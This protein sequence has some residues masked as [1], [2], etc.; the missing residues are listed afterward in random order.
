MAKNLSE[1]E[2]YKIE[3]YLKAGIRPG[4][5]AK[6]L[7]RCRATIYNEI[8]R[9]TCIQIDSELREYKTY[10]ADAGERVH[11]E[12]AAEKGR[13]PKIGN[14]MEF[15][16]HV[17]HMTN[18][19]KYSPFAIIADIENRGLDF[20]TKVCERTL[21][22][23]IKN[24]TFLNIKAKSKQKHE[25]KSKVSLN[26][27]KGRSIEERP[28][29]IKDRASYGHWEMDT[30]VSGQGKSKACLLVLTERAVR[31]EII[32]KMDNKKAESTVKALNSLEKK[33][34]AKNFRETFKTITVDNGVEFLDCSG[35]EKSVINKKLPR[36]T[37]YYCH[38]YSSYERGSNENQNRL[39]RKFVPKGSD[40][41][42]LSNEDILKIQDWMN[43][44]PRKLL[45]GK[46]ANMLKKELAA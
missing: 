27:L 23:Y 29:Y 3:G 41:S 20:K 21:Y 46:S 11:N 44:Y 31:E 43:N 28:D 40:I 35:L 6:L 22:N 14:D 33:L 18:N 30:V 42:Q 7:G 8:K 9:G 15:V 19:E 25:K 13:P 32:I 5:I 4:E 1:A 38:P 34:G 37:I 26:N 17:E 10:L 39:I 45:K 2:R 36:T 12:R 16:R 24:G